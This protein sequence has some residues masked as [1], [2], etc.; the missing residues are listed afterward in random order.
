MDFQILGPLEV[1]DGDRAVGLRGGKQ[2]ALLAL[3]LVNAGRTLA[4]DRTVDELW[5]EDVPESAQKMVQ[6]YVSKLRKVLPPGTLHTRPP[7]Y[8]LELEPDE[9]DLHRFERLV[10]DAGAALAA[11]QCEE[12]AAGF[13][14]A[15]DLWRGP[16]LAEFTSEPFAAPEGARLEEQRMRA[17]EGRI[18]A[19]LLRDRHA[20]L[21]GELEALVGRNP[22]RERPRQ[23]YMLALYRSGRQAEALA[24]YQD[25]RR[26]LADELGIDPSPALRELE[27]R[28]LQQDPSL[29][30]VGPAEPQPPR[31]RAAARA[32]QP[33]VPPASLERPEEMLKL[34]TVLFADIVGSTAWAETR[35]PEDVRDLMADYFAAMAPEIVSEGGT[36]EKF[37]GDAIMAVF[38]VPTVHEDDAVRAVRTAWRMLDRLRSWN[39]TRR[40]VQTLEIR[41]GVS[42]GEV[43]VSGAAGD[44][45]RITGEA[46]NLA[47]RLEQAA[48]PGTILVGERTARAA[49]SAFE[50]QAVDPLSLKGRSTPVAAWVVTAQRAQVLE[51]APAGATPLVGRDHELALC[52]RPS[53]TS[54][55]RVGPP[56]SPWSE[57]PVSAR[58]GSRPSASAKIE[59]LVA[60]RVEPSSP[61]TRPALP[62]RWP[63]RSDCGCE[64][65]HSRRSIRASST[66]SWSGRSARSSRRWGAMRPSSRSSRTSTGRI[67]R[68]STS[69][70]SSPSGS[71]VRSSSS[72]RRVPTCSA[73]APTG[74]PDSAASARCRSTR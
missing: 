1:R 4:I 10:A 49:G 67:R 52:R 73:R 38:G 37:V 60:T 48:E 43:L 68:C 65:I 34:V 64:E 47:A 70:T 59:E 29:D 58:A 46:V 55:W 74:A 39:E 72:V 2:Q 23:Q 25:V 17:L 35:H 19:D 61:T 54:A 69:S 5:G 9:L 50:L 22:L 15:L 12:A 18:E 6:I 66:A 56:S 45:L 30:H 40:P 8:A 20:D 62:R 3:L 41:V 71:T 57:T 13:R 11:G 31:A 53:T 51:R 42:T 27:R 7:G 63:R 33:A 14:A 36:I 44:D 32:P 28:I 16:A 21:V 26:A 24:A